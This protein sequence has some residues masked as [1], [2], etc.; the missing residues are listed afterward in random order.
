MTQR[1]SLGGISAAAQAAGAKPRRIL[2]VD[3]G[4]KRIGLALSDELGITAQPLETLVRTN[5][6]SDLRRLREICRMHSVG[7]IIVG[8]PLHM[9]G[10][11]GPMAEEAARFAARLEKGIGIDVELADE[12]L[13]SWEAE[14]TMA[15]TKAPAR[16]RRGPLDDVAAAILLRDYLEQKRGQT[17]SATAEKD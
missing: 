12:R 8:Y 16:R 2:A 17:P 6:Q 5:R 1:A 13:T 11:A 15:E 9:T 14:Q 10:E 7:H 3:Y 4:R